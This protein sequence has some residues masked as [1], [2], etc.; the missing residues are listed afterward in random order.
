MKKKDKI[1][2]HCWQHDR[3]YGGE[4]SLLFVTKKKKRGCDDLHSKYPRANSSF[5][6]FITNI[7]A[8]GNSAVYELE[9]VGTS[10]GRFYPPPEA[11]HQPLVRFAFDIQREHI[12]ARSSHVVD[13]SITKTKGTAQKSF[14]LPKETMPA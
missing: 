1:L 8:R 3:K 11:P 13:C 6:F 2:N 4:I 5:V 9:S 7:S 14:L 10:H 12:A